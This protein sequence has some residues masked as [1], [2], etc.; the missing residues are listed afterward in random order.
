[1]GLKTLKRWVLAFARQTGI[2]ESELNDKRPY[3]HGNLREQLLR[4]GEEA[5]AEIPI[6]DVS[7]REIARRAGVSHAAPKHYFASMGDLLGEIA[8]RG[9]QKFVQTLD[10]ASRKTNQQTA[11]GRLLAMGWAYLRFA[12]ANPAIYGLMFGKVD[13]MAVTPNMVQSSMAAWSQLENAVADLI[14]QARAPSGALHVWS[15]VHGLSMLKAER[16]LPPQLTL[17]AAEENLLRMMVQ[18]LSERP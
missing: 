7:L 2:G 11:E 10:E 9:F 3:H 8:A 4:T 17:H 6:E 18:G 1:M 12:E 14:G 13:R 5:L 15:S 16:R